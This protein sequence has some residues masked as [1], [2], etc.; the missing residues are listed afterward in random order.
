M[1]SQPVT[2]WGEHTSQPCLVV[3]YGQRSGG[4][5][6]FPGWFFVLFALSRILDGDI[7]DKSSTWVPE[8]VLGP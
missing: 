2:S 1:P 8:Y 6:H 5:C 3:A 7:Q 4:G